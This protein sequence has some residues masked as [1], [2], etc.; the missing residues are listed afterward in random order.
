MA[1]SSLS[2]AG[3]LAYY[4]SFKADAAAPALLARNDTVSTE[5]NPP[6]NVG[7]GSSR[8]EPVETYGPSGKLNGEKTQKSETGTQQQD[9]TEEQGNL[10]N[11][12]LSGSEES[13][14]T[15]EEEKEIRALKN[16]DTEVK[17]HEQAHIAAAGRYARGGAS[18]E[19]Q[20]GPDGEK[21]AVG[22]EVSIDVSKE[23]GD[24]Q[25]TITKMQTVIRA[26][27][28]P[29]EP[30]GQDRAVASKATRIEMDA[31]AEAAAALQEDNVD[32]A[33]SPQTQKESPS[34]EPYSATMDASNQ[35]SS[36][37]MYI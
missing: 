10:G 15:P 37:D 7:R 13:D 28:A 33:Q 1:V 34:A 25:A 20:T 6:E 31:R 11:Q 29:A 26:A 35:S 5:L 18:F 36:I 19:Y 12:A 3:S 8:E 9:K 4:P 21:Y 32:N 2:P 23:S 22:G 16:R 24:P 30:S 14:Y 17:A 27:L